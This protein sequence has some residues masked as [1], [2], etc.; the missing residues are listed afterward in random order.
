MFE[1]SQQ[2]LRTANLDPVEPDNL[3]SF[4]TCVCQVLDELKIPDSEMKQLGIFLES[5]LDPELELIHHQEKVCL[6]QYRV[7]KL[8]PHNL[9][10]RTQ[11]ATSLCKLLEMQ[12]NLQHLSSKLADMQEDLGY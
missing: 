7:W 8:D 1:L 12:P 3:Q 2:P 5:E 9:D 4:S 11:F 6:V 10:K